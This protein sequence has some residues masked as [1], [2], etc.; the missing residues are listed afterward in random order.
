MCGWRV[1]I[2]FLAG[3]RDSYFLHNIQPPGQLVVMTCTSGLKQPGHEAGHLPVYLL[4]LHLHTDLVRTGFEKFKFHTEYVSNIC[5]C[6]VID[7]LTGQT[8]IYVACLSDMILQSTSFKDKYGPVVMSLS[9]SLFGFG[10]TD[11]Y[12]IYLFIH[13]DLCHRLSVFWMASNVIFISV[14]SLLLLEILDSFPLFLI[15]LLRTSSSQ[16][17]RNIWDEEHHSPDRLDTKHYYWP[18]WEQRM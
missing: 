6:I 9:G 8:V 17:Q 10:R 12:V 2:W 1:V 18:N 13:I 16:K 5:I 4:C 14:S 11:M 7:V 15:S 3:A